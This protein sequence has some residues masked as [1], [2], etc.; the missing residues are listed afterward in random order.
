MYNN[1]VIIISIMYIRDKNNQERL[2]SKA[3]Q[4]IKLVGILTR[5][6]SFHFHFLYI[7]HDDFLSKRICCA[8]I[9]GL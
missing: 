7:E 1:N 8:L 3:E 4:T 5:R 2:C 9:L 6:F